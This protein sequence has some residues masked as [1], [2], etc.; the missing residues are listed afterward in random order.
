MKDLNLL[1][2]DLSPSRGSY[3]LANSLKKI[4]L[5]IS[6]VFILAAII[7]GIAIVFLSNQVQTSIAR[8][9][10]LKQK[11]QSLEVTEQKLF[12]IKDR[13]AKIQTAQA[14]QNAESPFESLNQVLSNLP[15]GVSVS[16]VNIDTSATSFSVTSKDSL[17]MASFLNLIVTS[18]TYKNL[19]VKGFLFSQDVGY[20]IALE[21]I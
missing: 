17:G 20:T 13:L 14:A 18:G 2:I 19:V 6:G 4:I 21:V 7:G 1:P 8:Q 5:S 3:K 10:E 11:I 9:T 15:D 12:L 16:T